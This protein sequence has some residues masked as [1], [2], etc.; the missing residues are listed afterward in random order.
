MPDG[1]RQPNYFRCEYHGWTYRNTGEL[2]GI[3][4][5]GGYAVEELDGIPESLD[6]I[7][8]LESYRG[9]VFGCLDPGAQ[10]LR[11]FLGVTTRYIDDWMDA[12]PTGEI[13]VTGGVWKH[14][15]QANWKIGL[16]GSDERY[17]VDMLHK[18][19]RVLIERKTG[20]PFRFQPPD[21]TLLRTIDAGN[22]H[23]ISEV[24]SD[25][26]PRPWRSRIRP[27]TS[28]H[29]SPGWVSNA[30]RKCSVAG[31]GGTRSPTPPS[32]PTT[33]ECCDQSASA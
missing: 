28:R 8:R 22:G 2:I 31:P 5:K 24:N 12:S 32:P 20:K 18:A 30:P 26:Y 3:T 29:S 27:S 13:V 7:P 9:L 15:Y 1:A 21:L 17:H 16:E 10:P 6:V 23:G 33:S 25:E 19:L 14:R 4:Q 11:D